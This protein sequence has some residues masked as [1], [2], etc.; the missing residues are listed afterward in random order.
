MKE[1]YLPSQ[2]AH[3]R[4]ISVMQS[5][6]SSGIMGV[7]VVDC[8]TSSILDIPSSMKQPRDTQIGWQVLRR[9]LDEVMAVAANNGYDWEILRTKL[10]TGGVTPLIPNRDPDYGDGREIFSLTIG[11]IISVRTLC[12]RFWL[13]TSI[14]GDALVEN[15]I[16]S[17]PRTCHEIGGTNEPRGLCPII[18]SV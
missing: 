13:P 10:R 6:P 4:L 17:I 9:N 5:L 18:S 15:L 1:S 8:K 12:R 7:V 14:W 11:R 2:I 3:T 16:R